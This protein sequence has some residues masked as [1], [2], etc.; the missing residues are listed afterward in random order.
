MLASG[1]KR[2]E[3]KENW[4][5]SKPKEKVIKDDDGKTRQCISYPNT[6]SFFFSNLVTWVS[7]RITFSLI[8]GGKKFIDAIHIPR[9][10]HIYLLVC[11]HVC[12]LTCMMTTF[13]I[14]LQSSSDDQM[15][16]SDDLQYKAEERGYY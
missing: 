8:G 2:E 4:V 7:V 5:G 10:I 12:V 11:V 1:E 15:Y 6:I 14:Y 13:S 3:R 16:S 9:Y